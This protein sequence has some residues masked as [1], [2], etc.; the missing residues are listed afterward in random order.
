MN[1]PLV[2]DRQSHTLSRRNISP[3]ALKVLYTLNE[4]GFL[5]YLAGG[6]VRDLLLGRKPKDFD[7]VTDATPN[8]L[9]K[10][11]RNC[12]LIGRRFR[13]AHIHFRNQ[14]IEVA[15]FRA[16]SGADTAA[17]TGVPAP[18]DATHHHRRSEHQPE[19]GH[20]HR[21]QRPH[22]DQPATVK[23]K[24]GLIL[25][26]NVFGTPEQDARRRDF[27]VNALFYNI[28][29]YG[30]IDYVGG[31]EDLRHRL[32]RSIGDP[33]TRYAEDPVRMVRAVRFAAALDFHIEQAA[34]DAIVK[35][36]GAIA[37]ASNARLYEEVM[38]LFLCGA[39]EKALA[40]LLRTGMF[41]SLFP[42]LGAWIKHS[43]PECKT[44]W[45]RKA[46]VK[47]DGWVKSHVEVSP[48]ML[49]ATLFADFHE[50]MAEE[51]TQ[52]QR[53]RLEKALASFTVQHLAELAP[54]IL[55]PRR[56]GEQMT[57]ILLDALRAAD[58][59]PHHGGP[60]PHLHPQPHNRQHV[61]H[62]QAARV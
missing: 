12:R 3:E 21:H 39:A 6:G 23:T 18:P 31:L 56:V 25:R 24:E 49:F 1:K 59:L 53:I 26:D 16:D 47:I 48:A 62:H 37:K 55:I 14:I 20:G 29:G 43:E 13:L 45:L 2:I 58:E 8:Q 35:S 42:Q 11:F 28:D 60:Q 52:H 4:C 46:C 61:V 17:G 9:R 40:L 19:H 7:V 44:H 5:G 51:A 27:T 15:T 30:I 10:V 38:K 50:D 22:P 36:H 33:M 41:A 32:I 34:Y 54:R 57:R